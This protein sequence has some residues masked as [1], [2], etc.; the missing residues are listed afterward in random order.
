MP[1]DRPPAQPFD[2]QNRLVLPFLPIST[3]VAGVKR[4]RGHPELDL[5]QALVDYHEIAAS[6]DVAQRPT[7]W[8]QVVDFLIDQANVSV[9][10][11]DC[12][13]TEPIQH[14]T[15]IERMKLTVTCHRTSAPPPRGRSRHGAPL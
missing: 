4:T 10:W 14:G 5:E 1:H 7:F 8:L 13:T 12:E 6:L 15:P 11:L 9:M 2:A 3:G